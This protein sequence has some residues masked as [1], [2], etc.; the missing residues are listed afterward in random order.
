MADVAG[1]IRN[2]CL[3]ELRADLLPIR[4]LQL[5]ELLSGPRTTLGSLE[6]LDVSFYLVYW[7]HYMSIYLSPALI[8]SILGAS[9]KIR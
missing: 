7:I 8:V 5:I 3:T 6:R 1:E 2:V 4:Q 9:L